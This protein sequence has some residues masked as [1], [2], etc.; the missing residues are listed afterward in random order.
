MANVIGLGHVGIYVHN[1][2][3]MVAFYRD[4][5]GMRVTKQN[6]RAGIVFLSANPSH[7][8]F[9]NRIR[10]I[11]T[12]NRWPQTPVQEY[13]ARKIHFFGGRRKRLRKAEAKSMPMKI[14]KER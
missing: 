12:R 5:L 10:A 14:L 8:L 9:R 6:W 2:E 4:T 1:L 7:P 3:R 13:S 11:K